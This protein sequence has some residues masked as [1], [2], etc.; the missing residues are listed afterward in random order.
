MEFLFF[1]RKDEI[2][3]AIATDEGLVGKAAFVLFSWDVFAGSALLVRT[4]DDG[5]FLGGGD[6][7]GLRARIRIRA[8]HCVCSV[9]CIGKFGK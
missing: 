8:A 1:G 7:F 5:V 9:V 4:V 3:F 2:S 6:G